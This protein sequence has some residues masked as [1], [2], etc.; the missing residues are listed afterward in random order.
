MP[1]GRQVK[2]NDREP[3]YGILTGANEHYLANPIGSI[4]LHIIHAKKLDTRTIQRIFPTTQLLDYY[5]RV[6][7]A[8]RHFFSQLC[9]DVSP[10]DGR[11]VFDHLITF[12]V[13]D[14]L[15]NEGSESQLVTFNL[16]AVDEMDPMRHIVVGRSEKLVLDFIQNMVASDLL[17]LSRPAKINEIDGG[18]EGTGRNQSINQSIEQSINQPPID[19]SIERSISQSIKQIQSSQSINQSVDQ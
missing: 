10:L 13:D 16:V 14:I 5:V 3:F 15:P 8:D 4:T 18:Y 6:D 2:H 7:Y 17:D 11:V 19:Q 12:T 1:D 9:V